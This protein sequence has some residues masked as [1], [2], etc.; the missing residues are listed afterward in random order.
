MGKIIATIGGIGLLSLWAQA[1]NP[2]T[3][4]W[5]DGYRAYQDTAPEYVEVEIQEVKR[6]NLK[7]LWFASSNR[8]IY[9]QAKVLK[10]FRSEAGLRP[11]H[12]IPILYKRKVA[13]GLSI[14][15]EPVPPPIGEIVP[16]F[17]KYD[18][19]GIFVPAALHHTFSSLAPEQ[20]TEN[21]P[22][23]E[24]SSIPESEPL[25]EY[26]QKEQEILMM[27]NLQD[28]MPD[29]PEN[30]EPSDDVIFVNSGPVIKELGP[31]PAIE[32]SEPVVAEDIASETDPIPSPATSPAPDEPETTLAVPAPVESATPVEETAV[33]RNEPAA[34]PEVSEPGSGPSFK[35]ILTLSDGDYGPPKS[36]PRQAEP[37]V[38]EVA[39]PEAPV[40]EVTET[41]STEPPA[42]VMPEEEIPTDASIEDT[43]PELTA[44]T[45]P[46][47]VETEPVIVEVET[48]AAPDELA[49]PE[50]QLTGDNIE[51]ETFDEIASADNAP[52]IADYEVLNPNDD[53]S[54]GTS[55]SPEATPG[56]LDLS[57]EDP[58]ENQDAIEL[59]E[60]ILTTTPDAAA[61][62]SPD[63]PTTQPVSP[64]SA[65]DKEPMQRYADIFLQ[66]RTAER[67]INSS[68]YQEA[69]PELQGA[70]EKIKSLRED[71]PDFQPFMVEYR[72][73]TTERALQEISDKS[74]TTTEQPENPQ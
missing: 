16:A 46:V 29:L 54:V 31:A 41:T 74:S 50:A 57:Q 45:T 24:D 32:A 18:G 38:V 20:K 26:K 65:D 28:E 13:A 2:Y 21:S 68:Q 72:Q 58:S 69:V 60:P 47:V 3:P 48:T 7:T 55:S 14:G 70:L 19:D 27:R 66:V 33:A 56:E 23:D 49:V 12:L 43:A 67:M 1:S 35:G 53:P 36:Q 52:S 51:A 64:A 34:E 6:R 5:D 10:V 4:N 9:V 40:I 11:G 42:P 44:D 71:Y 22:A 61:P 25:P 15:D 39:T 8:D 63:A 59:V 37:P 73:R 62:E 17:L 30:I